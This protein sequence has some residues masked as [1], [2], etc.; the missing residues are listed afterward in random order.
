MVTYRRGPRLGQASGLATSWPG[1]SLVGPACHKSGRPIVG[2]AGPD[3]GSAPQSGARGVTGPVGPCRRLAGA[4]WPAARARY[5]LSSGC[6]APDWP[7]RRRGPAAWG[8]RDR[9]RLAT[10]R[11][12]ASRPSL[13]AGLRRRVSVAPVRPTTRHGKSASRQPLP[14]VAAPPSRRSPPPEPLQARLTLIRHGP[15]ATRPLD[16]PSRLGLSTGTGPGLRVS[17]PA[18]PTGSGCAPERRSAARAK[19]P[20]AVLNGPDSGPARPHPN[21]AGMGCF[22]TRRPAVVL[23]APA[24]PHAVPPPCRRDRQS[25]DG[26]AQD[27]LAFSAR[28]AARQ[29]GRAIKEEA[30]PPCPPITRSA[31]TD[32]APLVPR[33]TGWGRGGGGPEVAEDGED[34][35]AAKELRSWGGG[36]E[37]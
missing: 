26:A 21:G 17:W 5:G 18:P 2:E 35:D 32:P 20:R 37:G 24:I 27:R 19:W 14:G 8:T 30:P 29:S 33:W 1:L 36:R 11:S 25:R 22:A 6:P 23:A 4:D 28:A 12:R 9:P 7:R 13:G 31:A 15:G 34:A 16:A 3:P 10:S